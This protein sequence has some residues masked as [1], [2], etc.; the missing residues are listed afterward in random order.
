MRFKFLYSS[1]S[2]I[3][4]CGPPFADADDDDKIG[5][6]SFNREPTILLEPPTA[7]GAASSTKSL[8]SES[9]NVA[10]AFGEPLKPLKLLEPPNPPVDAPLNA[11]N[12]LVMAAIFGE[13]TA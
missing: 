7:T 5:P 3:G 8:S 11:P 1:V 10:A 9:S 4:I 6:D 13:I 12:L 2:S